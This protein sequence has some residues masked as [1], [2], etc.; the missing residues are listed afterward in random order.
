MTPPVCFS[1]TGQSPHYVPLYQHAR[2]RFQA[3]LDS[4]DLRYSQSGCPGRPRRDVLPGGSPAP[5]RT[6]RGGG[7]WSGGGAGPGDSAAGCGDPEIRPGLRAATK[8]TKSVAEAGTEEPSIVSTVASEK[9]QSSWLSCGGGGGLGPDAVGPEGFRSL[10]GWVQAPRGPRLQQ[11]CD[12]GLRHAGAQKHVQCEQREQP[13]LRVAPGWRVGI[14]RVGRRVSAAGWTGGAEGRTRGVSCRDGAVGVAAAKG[15]WERGRIGVGIADSGRAPTRCW[16]RDPGP[17]A[18]AHPR[19]GRARRRAAARRTARRPAPVRGGSPPGSRAGWG[20]AARAAPRRGRRRESG[21][22]A[23]LTQKGGGGRW[24]LC[25]G[26]GQGVR[27]GYLKERDEGGQ[28]LQR[29]EAADG[30]HRRQE[31]QR[32]Q[33]AGGGG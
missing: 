17:A 31:E 13:R 26:G 15:A 30:G 32:H 2:S 28:P 25:A 5:A 6:W 18:G 10:G 14:W 12:E 24:A 21:L 4:S 3:N 19:A 9:F 16:L 8:V 22:P 23:Q 29:G 27:P 20:A 11:Q 33:S 7:G 1:K